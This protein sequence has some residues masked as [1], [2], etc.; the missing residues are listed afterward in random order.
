MK[1]IIHNIKHRTNWDIYVKMF[2]QLNV[3]FFFFVYEKQGTDLFFTD[4]I[5]V[6]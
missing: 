6:Y 2:N 5:H 4:L 3:L 1:Q